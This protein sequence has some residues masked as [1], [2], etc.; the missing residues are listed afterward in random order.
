M[1]GV[2]A[3][4][5]PPKVGALPK[6]TKAPSPGTAG[7]KVTDVLDLMLSLNAKLSEKPKRKGVKRRSAG[8]RKK[9][10]VWPGRFKKL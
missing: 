10:S 9:R 5:P 6:K 2:Q 7:V 4:P 8:Y 3:G 1:H